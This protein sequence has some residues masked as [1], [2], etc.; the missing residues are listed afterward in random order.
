MIR[1]K[2]IEASQKIKVGLEQR[3]SNLD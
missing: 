2:L 1:D 3:Q